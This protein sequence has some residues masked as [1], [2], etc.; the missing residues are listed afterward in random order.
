M[1]DEVT[2]TGLSDLLKNLRELPKA[3]EQKCLKIAVAA[4]AQVIRKAA[5]D[6]V[7]QKTG[8]VKK[9]IRIGYNRKESAPG[10]VV[11]HVFVSRKVK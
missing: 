11:Y 2:I 8:L 5:Q 10:K 9:A 3:I 7:R 1:A 4:G 6:L